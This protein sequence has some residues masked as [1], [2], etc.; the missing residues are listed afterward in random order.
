MIYDKL[1][2]IHSYLGISAGIKTALLYLRDI[3][4]EIEIGSYQISSSVKVIVSSYQTLKNNPN[5][6]EAHR[7]NIDIQYLIT[8]EEKISYLPVENLAETVAYND[9]NDI[10]F[11][12]PLATP[13]DLTI[14]NGYF[15][16][17][18][19]Q[20]GHMPQQC[21]ETPMEVKKIVI[22]IKV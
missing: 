20:D 22:K 8:G 21:L 18:F 17:L 11:Y 7:K 16:I 14:G 4:S 19:P 1:E 15:T 2:N 10:A 12:R 6:Y 13:L 3:N 5:G 9:D